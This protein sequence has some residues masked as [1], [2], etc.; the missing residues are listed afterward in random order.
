M[1]YVS[2]LKKTLNWSELIVPVYQL[3]RDSIYS[4]KYSYLTHVVES[5]VHLSVLC[6][7]NTMCMQWTREVVFMSQVDQITE[8]GI[9][10]KTIETLQ[11]NVKLSVLDSRKY[12]LLGAKSLEI[13]LYLSWS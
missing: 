12:C 8:T 2:T 4:Q 3:D 10:K 5:L 1:L 7:N 11:K 6:V 13:L 9:I